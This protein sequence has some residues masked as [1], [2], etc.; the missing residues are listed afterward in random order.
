LGFKEVVVRL[1]FFTLAA[2]GAIAIG[3]SLAVG[4][5]T[6][7]QPI[8]LTH[9]VMDAPAP[10]A[11]ASFGPGPAVTTGTAIC[12]TASQTVNANTDCETTS[13]GPHNET[14]IAVNPT[15]PLNMIGGAN[16]YQ[17]T[18]NPDGHITET[19]LSRAHVTFDGGK[20]WSMY[21]V[22]SNSSYQATGDPALAFDAA[23]TAYYSTLGFRFVGP[24]VLSPDVLVSHSTDGGKTWTVVRVAS[25]SGVFTSVGDV[26]DKEYVAAWGPGNAIVVYGDFRQGQ[27][28]SFVSAIIHSS[29]T[30]DGGNTWSAL[31]VIS[32][33]LT[34]AFVAT[35]V[36]AADGRI[37]VSFL[38]T[39]DLNTGRDDYEVV[40]VS[41]ATGAALGDPVKVATTIDGFTDYPIAFGRQTYQDSVFRSWAAGNIAADPTNAKHLAVVWSDMRDSITPAP[42]DPYVAKTN[43]DIVVSQSFDRGKT[44]SAPVAFGQIGDQ[45]MPWSAYDKLGRL[46][47]GFF[48]RSVD[49]NNHKYAYSLATE[50]VAGSLNFTSGTVSTVNSDPTKG[51]R[52]FARNVNA[53]FPHA[54]A[55][56]G[57][58]SNIAVMPDGS[59]VAYWTDMRNNV[60]FL[61]VTRKGEDAYFGTAS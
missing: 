50:N 30:H 23:G 60:T 13:T 21:P 18:L 37:F 46:R 41:P 11:S 45:F 56:L 40:E 29:V 38:N 16:D 4:A 14:S 59:V 33:N 35:P 32:G 24:D 9:N 39:T 49:L 3:Q 25:G 36:V 28:G 44:W 7:P 51:D 12:T 22:F 58:Y 52:W 26:L 57:D 47:I 53:N 5:D 1:K 2:L 20:T 15:N 19:I 6:N 8:D 34:E 31:N 61:G 43:S 54:T 17:L 55:F 27:K 48:D 10:V 42:S